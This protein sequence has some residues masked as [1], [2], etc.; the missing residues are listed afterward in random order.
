V[1]HADVI[2]V[3]QDGRIIEQGNHEALVRRDGVYAELHRQQLL[4]EELAAS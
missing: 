3:L 2:V 1:R 4:Q